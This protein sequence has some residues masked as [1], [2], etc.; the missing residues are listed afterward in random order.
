MDGKLVFWTAAFL[1]MA[2]IVVLAGLGVRA[3]R[4]GAI[5]R[6]RRAMLTAAGLVALFLLA[7]ALKLPLLGREDTA[8]WSTAD[9]WLLRVHELCVAVMLLAGALAASRARRL[10]RTRNATRRPEDPLAAP[11]T[12]RWHRGPGWTA[13]AAAV[14][15][16]LTAGL[17]LLGMYERAG[18]L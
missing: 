12:V 3:R 11:R 15:G 9:L 17:V 6:H 4:L 10:S 13:V 8:S 2:A 1:N 5:A 18:L 7:Y 16:F 14:L